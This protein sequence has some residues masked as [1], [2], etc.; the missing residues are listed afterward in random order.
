MQV[1]VLTNSALRRRH[2]HLHAM[3]VASPHAF[4]ERWVSGL[5]LSLFTKGIWS[6]DFALVMLM[7]LA[8]RRI[9]VS[10]GP[11]GLYYSKNQTISRHK[12]RW[13]NDQ[14]ELMSECSVEVSNNTKSGSAC[15]CLFFFFPHSMNVL[16]EDRIELDCHVINPLYSTGEWSATDVFALP[17]EGFLD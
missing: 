3:V 10:E 9:F 6:L 15:N 5:I 16:N 13:S 7:R 2:P 17:P 1:R 12:W 11:C 8:N 14:G 4:E